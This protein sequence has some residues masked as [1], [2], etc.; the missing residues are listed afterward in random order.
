MKQQKKVILVAGPTASGKSKLAIKLAKHLNGE[1][2]NADSM[3]IYREISIL[4]SKPSHR[5]RKIIKHHLYG[6]KSVKKKFSTGLWLKMVIKKIEKQWK[7][8]KIPIVV[9]GT[10][11][12]FK[13]LTDGLVNIPN[14]PDNFRKKVRFLHKKLGQKKFFEQ[15]IKI[16]F[17]SKKY[18]SPSDSQRSMRAYEVKKFTN[19]SLFKFIKQ[20][21]S[22]FQKDVFIK[23]FINIPK[24]L[25][26]K[27]IEK[28]VE[29]M[30]KEGA[31]EEVKNFL[32]IKINKD[33]S[34]KKIIGI[35]EIDNYLNGK[36]KLIKAKELIRQKTR[37]YAKRQFTWARGHMKS[38]EM[39]YSYD[40][41][42][43]FKKAINKIS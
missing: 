39:I 28:R 8:G 36:I 11:L 23:L 27:K 20:T 32:K 1:I 43:L 5:D 6:F 21:K 26:Y 10:G 16:D 19:K 7:D 12:Y 24:D 29:I 37:Q 34:S 41:N 2:I 9:G 38:W 35:K 18:I 13:A 15:L 33:L 17:L 14:I 42:D 25:L 31:I 40:L 4:T 22:N 3:Q 30:F